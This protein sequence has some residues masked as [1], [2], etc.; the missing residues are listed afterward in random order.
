MKQTD[1]DKETERI[2]KQHTGKAVNLSLRDIQE[3]IFLATGS[4]PSTEL[5]GDSLRRHGLLPTGHRWFWQHNKCLA[6][7]GGHLRPA[8][9][10]L[11]IYSELV[12]F[13]LLLAYRANSASR[14]V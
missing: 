3:L 5:I 7:F 11:M 13:R 10:V 8:W 1:L 4:K 6:L 9:Y 2:A 12:A 14:Y